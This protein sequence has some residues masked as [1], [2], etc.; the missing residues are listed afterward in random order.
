MADE[1]SFDEHYP[2]LED[3]QLLGPEARFPV[4]GSQRTVVIV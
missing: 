4:G 2:E 3:E 1:V